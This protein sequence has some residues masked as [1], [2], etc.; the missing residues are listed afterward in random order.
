MAGDVQVYTDKDMFIYYDSHVSATK[1]GVLC[2]NNKVQRLKHKLNCVAV[3]GDRIATGSDILRIYSTNDL[4]AD[5]KEK[6]DQNDPKSVVQQVNAVVFKTS[7]L[8]YSA[9]RDTVRMHDT[10]QR[11][12]ITKRLL[13]QD[14]SIKKLLLLG[15][16][17]VVS[18]NKGTVYVLDAELKPV[19]TL[20]HISASVTDMVLTTDGFAVCSMDRF[21]RCFDGDFRLS[22]KNY[23]KNR[24]TCL[25]NHAETVESLESV[26]EEDE[27]H[28]LVVVR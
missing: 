27:W 12:P 2:F 5:Y 4:T 8:L 6:I 24:P 23:I 17:V 11:K 3:C 1:N 14:A 25:V 13:S 18:T 16:N 10:R 7:T 26:Q 21:V 28:G 9:T 19:K 20:D 15:E 22:S